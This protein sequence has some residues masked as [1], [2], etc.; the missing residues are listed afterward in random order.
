[1]RTSIPLAITGRS[2]GGADVDAKLAL[3]VDGKID[4]SNCIQ[5]LIDLQSGPQ[6]TALG[7]CPDGSAILTVILAVAPLVDGRFAVLLELSHPDLPGGKRT[8][9]MSGDVA[10]NAV[11][12]RKDFQ[13]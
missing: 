12:Y 7:P 11:R 9:K 4:N 8:L 5:L 1:M 6:G 13:L 10:G 2:L 3:F